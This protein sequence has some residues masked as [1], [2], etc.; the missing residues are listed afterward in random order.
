[1]NDSE[2]GELL[3]AAKNVPLL[4][5]GINTGIIVSTYPTKEHND[6]LKA[7]K[8]GTTPLNTSLGFRTARVPTDPKDP[9]YSQRH[10]IQT[11]KNNALT[12]TFKGNRNAR[13]GKVEWEEYYLHLLPL[14]IEHPKLLMTGGKDQVSRTI[15]KI[16]KP[17]AQFIGD[18]SLNMEL[19]NTMK[20]KS[21][22][23]PILADNPF[24]KGL[25]EDD[26]I[27][28]IA[29]E[30][31]G[32]SDVP[33]DAEDLRKH[34]N[35]K[36]Q[37]KKALAYIRELTNHTFLRAVYHTST[38]QA[39]I[40]YKEVQS[41]FLIEH[42]NDKLR[43]GVDPE[44][45]TALNIIAHIMKECLCENDKSLV[46]IQN[47]FNELIRHN[48]QSPLQW[49]QT[50]LPIQTRYRKALGKDLDANAQK[51]VWKLHFARQI[52]IAEQTTI[53]TFR[54]MHLETTEIRET[55]EM[56]DGKFDEQALQK[57]F[58]RL[59]NSFTTYAPDKGVMDYLNQHASSLHWEKKLDFRTPREKQSQD[60]RTNK[61]DK[62]KDRADRNKRRPDKQT[63]RPRERTG[64][65]K[66]RNRKP[67]GGSDR[68]RLKTSRTDTNS[69]I[70]IPESEQCRRPTCRERG[71]HLNHSHAKCRFA[72][73]SP[74]HPNLG[75]APGKKGKKPGGSSTAAKTHSPAQRPFKAPAKTASANTPGE[76][77]L[78]YICSSEDH[79][80]NACPQKEQNKS[81]ARSFL[82]K[83]RNFMA[84]WD[85]K[86]QSTEEKQC[87]DRVL[88]A[89]DDSNV[90]P[91]CIKQ[92]EKGHKCDQKDAPI[93]DQMAYVRQAIGRTL[94]LKQIKRAH[95]RQTSAVD[96]P[97][98]ITMG[99]NF[100]NDSEGQHSS[101]EERQNLSDESDFHEKEAYYDT[102]S[103]HSSEGT[104]S[105]ADSTP[106][107]DDTDDSD[108][109]SEDSRS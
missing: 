87:A 91:I 86:F 32:I 29:L 108:S 45:F 105:E 30:D 3:K 17:S 21:L 97:T 101:T 48:G 69:K 106:N 92:M 85:E 66:D 61:H 64:R 31:E 16:F 94:L 35:V 84:L 10:L 72:D 68:K 41:T 76:K 39:Q 49:L 57:L 36:V 96:K 27:T 44:K 5:S 73:A 15:N 99:E 53:I 13:V 34:E 40:E 102:D 80:A 2:L 81:R 82:T 95:E 24:E 22:C 98:P 6:L 11:Y 100:F 4:N 56:M 60:T 59:S 55:E 52:T 28:E 54:S 23:L 79:L 50:M 70:R 1:M 25:K 46:L 19:Q 104:R 65:T 42:A 62:N 109:N 83:D 43:A 37:Y 75:K 7:G 18:A 93:H 89:W 26:L 51:R 58:T 74:R 8:P 33:E 90:C 38:H 71:N 88:D 12:M 63:D 20:V 77:R 78:C 14:V 9:N 107:R 67:D 47:T 103:S